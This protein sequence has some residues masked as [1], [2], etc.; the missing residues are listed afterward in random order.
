[1]SCQEVCEFV[2]AY[3]DQELDVIAS[4]Q[5]DRH[6][7]HCEACR[8]RYEQ[9]QQLR[10]SV[11][12]NMEYFHPSKEFEQRLRAQLFPAG[13]GERKASKQ[14]WFAGWQPWAVAAGLVG[15]LLFTAVLFEM[16]KRPSESDMLAQQVV[17]SHI[18]SLLANHLSDVISTDQHTVKP[19]F[20]GKL[21]FAPVV[22]DL[23]SQGF[24]LA[25][26][27]L[28]YL[29]DRN[30]A[31]LVY[32]RRQHKINLF[33]WPSPASDAGPR[34]LTIKGFNVVHWTHSQMAYWA[35]SDVSAGDLEEFSRDLEK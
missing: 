4:S 6:L 10:D 32:K 17:S 23:A 20:S 3:L 14:E 28:D 27:R 21:D 12:S 13:Q 7:K 16:A 24:P 15:V 8:A 22:R 35:V 19:W 34:T 18:R 31:A 11:R 1:M 26:G 29:N 30:V 25:G 9:H 2:D 33:L 5:F